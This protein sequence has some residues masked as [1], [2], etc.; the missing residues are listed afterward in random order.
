M[1]DAAIVAVMCS[2]TSALQPLHRG[3]EAMMAM[4]MRMMT[5]MIVVVAMAMAVAGTR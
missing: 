2:P 4:M 1:R 5:M 3:D